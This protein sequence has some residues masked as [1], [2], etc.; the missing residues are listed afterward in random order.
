MEPLRDEIRQPPRLGRGRLA[1]VLGV[2]LAAPAGAPL[3]ARDHRIVPMSHSVEGSPAEV[4]I[5]INPADP[6]NVVAVSLVTGLEVRSTNLSFFSRDGGLTWSSRLALNPERKVQGDDAVAFNRK[7]RAFRSYISFRGLRQ[8]SPNPSNGIFVSSSTDGGENWTDPVSVV[9]H[10]NTVSPFE[11]KPYLATDP[12]SEPP[13]PDR[14]YLAWT[15]FDH[16]GSEDPQD[17]SHIYASRSGD[18]G[19]SFSSPIRI[20]DQGG[21]CLDGDGT[22]EGAVPAVGVDG[23]VFVVW[24]GP[25]GLVLDVSHDSGAT[26]GPDT[27]IADMPGSWDLEIDGLG[28]A[29]GLPVTGVDHSTGRRRGTVYVNWVDERLGDA[30]VFLI[31][32]SDRGATWSAPVRVNDDPPGNGRPQFFTWMSVDPADGSVNIVFLD[33]RSGPGTAT[34]VTLARSV[35]GG[36]TFQNYP[37][38]LEPF[39]ADPAVFFGDYIGISA[40]GGLVIAA[41]PHFDEGGRLKLSA[42]VFRFEPGSQKTTAALGHPDLDQ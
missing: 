24:A 22:V 7:G 21:D 25:L 17:R 35:D 27:V 34:G 8:D 33:R 14:L 41:F 28:R 37:L 19:V 12:R 30:D 26:F 9:D 11:D 42:A 32:S 4:S 20:S 15:R 16:Y 23:R 13:Y 39:E 18:G 1:C 3:Q 2:I 38:H 29:N 36:R 6:L 31:R 10:R 5:A 40:H